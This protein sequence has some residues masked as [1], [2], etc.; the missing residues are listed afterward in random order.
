MTDL[1]KSIGRKRFKKCFTSKSHRKG[2]E[3][4]VFTKSFPNA[5]EDAFRHI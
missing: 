5:I 1:L 3:N 4:L 2:S